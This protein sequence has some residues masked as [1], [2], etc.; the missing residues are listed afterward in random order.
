[1]SK[2]LCA[3]RG[4][5]ASIRT[6]NAAIAR[7]KEEGKG[8]IFFLVMD[9]EF[10]VNADY[11]MRTD[12]VQKAM[13]GLGEFLLTV[14]VERGKA[15]GMEDVSYRLGQG[16]F[17]P[18][19]MEVIADEDISLIVLGIPDPEESIFTTLEGLESF[20]A[21]LKEQT[22]IDVWLAQ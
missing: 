21:H 22:G 19:L 9:V 16:H 20:A 6:Q 15:A 7:A 12:I 2:I 18:A 17:T 3:T 1:M 8:L 11:G 5:E 13:D 4:G 14:A 10:M